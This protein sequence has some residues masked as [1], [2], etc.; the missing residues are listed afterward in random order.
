MTL[1]AWL[2]DSEQRYGG[3]HSNVER[4]RVSP[5][6]P[7]P[8]R[9]LTRGGMTGGDRMTQH[10]Y[11]ATY[12]RTIEERHMAAVTPEVLR[13]LETKFAGGIVTGIRPPHNSPLDAE[14]NPKSVFHG[15]RMQPKSMKRARNYASAYAQHLPDT[16]C[17]FTLVELGILRGVGL[18]IWCDLFPSARVIGLDVD[19][20]HFNEN[21]ADLRKRGAFRK[22]API[23]YDYDELAPDN[24][25]RLR[26]ILNGDR[27][28]VCI[29]DALHY[30]A[31]I[32]K[33]MRDL[34]PFMGVGGTYFVEDNFKVHEQI[35]RL[36][37]HLEV[38]SIEE[39]TV[40]QC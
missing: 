32:L 38:Q 22:N 2:A 6:D 8:A 5:H 39:M 27:I 30:D 21:C 40:I 36:Y 7:R 10:G 1:S 37:P 25:T 9:K 12:A 31:A 35:S 23:V 26:S 13:S 15:H 19:V 33:A 16:R 20:S 29:D 11:A 18:A 17:T 24:A 14:P 28:D 34:M 4:R 3:L